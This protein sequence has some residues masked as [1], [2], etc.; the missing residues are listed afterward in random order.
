MEICTI[1]AQLSPF[2]PDTANCALRLHQFLQRGPLYNISLS[3]G[4]LI[5]HSP[6]ALQRRNSQITGQLKSDALCSAFMMYP[7]YEYYFKEL[8]S[9]QTL[10]YT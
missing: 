4:E 9:I 3:L 5:E 2:Y 7:T 1:S 6:I 10:E 8:T